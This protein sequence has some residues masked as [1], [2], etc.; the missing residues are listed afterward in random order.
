MNKLNDLARLRR[1][2]TVVDR[3]LKL[4]AVG[5]ELPPSYHA[6]AC[7]RKASLGAYIERASSVLEHLV[8]LFHL[9]GSMALGAT[10]FLSDAMAAQSHNALGQAGLLL[11]R[12]RIIR[13]DGPESSELVGLTDVRRAVSELP[14]IARHGGRPR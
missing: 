11:G 7:G 12:D 8:A 1:P 9:Q 3:L 2:E 5:V 13:I 10:P 4:V 6:F 14:G